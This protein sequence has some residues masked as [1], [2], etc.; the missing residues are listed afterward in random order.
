MQP[1]RLRPVMCGS[2]AR[3]SVIS[4]VLPMTRLVNGVLS[5]L[6][7]V[8]QGCACLLSRPSAGGP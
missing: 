2:L 7:Y 8:Q 5:S 6:A 3:Q 4:S 1:A